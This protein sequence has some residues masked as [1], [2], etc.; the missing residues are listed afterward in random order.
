MGFIFLGIRGIWCSKIKYSPERILL[1]SHL[2]LY[3]GERRTFF[4]PMFNKPVDTCNRVQSS[5]KEAQTNTSFSRGNVAV[6]FSTTILYGNFHNYFW[7]E[8]EIP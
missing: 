3:S 1:I 6:F 2:F 5:T 4:W 8:S 7:E